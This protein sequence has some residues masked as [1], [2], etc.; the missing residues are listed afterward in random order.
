MQT[1]QAQYSISY[2]NLVSD[3]GSADSTSLLSQVNHQPQVQFE[4]GY[5]IVVND[6]PVVV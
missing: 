1:P 3:L 5:R 6:Q 4:N 2:P